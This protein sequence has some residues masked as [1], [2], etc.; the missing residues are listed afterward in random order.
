[1][2]RNEDGSVEEIKIP[3]GPSGGNPN[4]TVFVLIKDRIETASKGR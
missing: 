1:M 2:H 3:S 4:M